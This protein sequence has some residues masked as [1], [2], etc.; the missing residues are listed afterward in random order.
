MKTFFLKILLVGA[1]CLVGGAVPILGALFAVGKDDYGRPL[2]NIKK[3]FPISRKEMCEKCFRMMYSG[4]VVED[5][6]EETMSP[7]RRFVFHCL[8]CKG[9]PRRGT[10]SSGSTDAS[11]YSHCKSEIV[12]LKFFV[13][14]EDRFFR[15]NPDDFGVFTLN[16]PVWVIPTAYRQDVHLSFLAATY[17]AQSLPPIEFSLQSVYNDKSFQN[18]SFYSQH[19]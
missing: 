16:S 3:Y 17:K 9:F 12:P 7:Y 8:D 15:V 14:Y 1:L 18:K 11:Y 2:V 4:C 19:P 13:I 6:N 10:L 5:I